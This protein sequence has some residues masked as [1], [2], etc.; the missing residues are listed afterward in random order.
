MSCVY[1][2]SLLSCVMNPCALLMLFQRLQEKKIIFLK[3][4]SLKDDTL[5]FEGGYRLIE[6]N[7]GFD[8]QEAIGVFGTLLEIK[9]F[10]E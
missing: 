2:E 9:S 4:R 6:S 5:S 8:G 10:L 7:K 1:F 3:D